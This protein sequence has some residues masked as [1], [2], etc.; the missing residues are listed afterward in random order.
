MQTSVR[1]VLGGRYELEERL[2]AGAT[3]TVWRAHDTRR[4][5]EVTVK[6]LHPH[7]LDDSVART[8]LELEA[9]SARQLDHPGIVPL[10]DF[11][12]TPDEA[13]LVFPAV[14][15]QTLSQ[16]LTDKRPLPAR[17]AAAIAAD[18]AEALAYAHAASVVHRDVKPANILVDADGRARLLDFG[19]ARSADG[20]TADLTAD[21][22]AVGTPPYVAPE[23][24]GGQAAEP[25]NDV[26]AL[27]AV[28]YE[29]LAGR[30]PYEERA[31]VALAEAQRKPPAAIPHA[32]EPLQALALAALVREPGARPAAAEVAHSLRAWLDGRLTHEAPTILAPL[33]VPSTATVPVPSASGRRGR[34][35]VLAGALLL[36]LAL[37]V[38]SAL[39]FGPDW[40][41]L[42]GTGPQAARNAPLVV[43]PPS[44]AEPTEGDAT[45]LEPAPEQQTATTSERDGGPEAKPS[46]DD[47]KSKGKGNGKGKGK[48]KP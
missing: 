9:A 28:L 8:R 40:A 24:L 16:R 21:G 44:T 4:D 1:T 46:K 45:V 17:Q 48:G 18:V 30:P 19:I 27:G 35:P 23:Q 7:L 32:P 20:L 37:A 25:A 3:A 38:A 29:M 42:T 15:G 36:T 12:A 34:K 43:A 47:K 31:P 14:E 41:D 5:S 10:I 33:I 11:V 6:V 2:G 22:M 13:A 39:A 26:Y